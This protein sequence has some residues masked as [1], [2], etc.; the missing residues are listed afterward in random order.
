MKNEDKPTNELIS[1]IK[2]LEIAHESVKTQIFKELDKL[3]RIE[4][5]YAE[6]KVILKDR[7]H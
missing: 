7:N 1:L 2:G 5:E 4:K 3:E 6:I